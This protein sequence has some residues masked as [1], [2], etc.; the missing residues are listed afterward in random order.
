MSAALGIGIAQN[1]P[2]ML[3]SPPRSPSRAGTPWR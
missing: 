3:P 2:P 1:V